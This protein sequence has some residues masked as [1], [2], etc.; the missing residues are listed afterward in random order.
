MSGKHYVAAVMAAVAV[1]ICAVAGC[2][3]T[4]SGASSVASQASSLATSSAVAKAK[5][6]AT[7]CLQKTGTSGLLTSSGRSQL[8]DCLKSIVPPA[9]QEAF[10]NCITSAATS[11]KIWTSD[12]RSKF[13]DTSLPNGVNAAG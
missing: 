5:N 6:E 4:S 11:D 13:M 2:S 3:S 1:L 7:A 10:K 8:I 12:G 9:Q